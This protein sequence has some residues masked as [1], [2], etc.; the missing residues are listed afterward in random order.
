VNPKIETAD[1][2]TVPV[3]PRD[4]W[5][6]CWVRGAIMLAGCM[7]MVWSMVG[8][9]TAPYERTHTYKHTLLHVKPREGRERK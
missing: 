8:V 3:V 2:L 4:M 1:T 5:F 9:I 7:E 6:I